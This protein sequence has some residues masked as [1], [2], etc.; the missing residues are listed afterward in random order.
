MTSVIVPKEEHKDVFEVLFDK[1]KRVKNP[2]AKKKM[3]RILLQAKIKRKEIEYMRDQRH[4]Q[5]LMNEQKG[6]I[7]GN[8][9]TGDLHA[10][11]YEACRLL[12]PALMHGDGV[13][14]KEGWRWIM[15]QSWGKEFRAAPFE[16]RH[17]H[18]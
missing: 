12:C 10:L 18:V 15:R 17:S 14:L 7:N 4:Y 1:W 11:E 2:A 6:N 9:V 3:G 5:R 13:A 16:K 8:L